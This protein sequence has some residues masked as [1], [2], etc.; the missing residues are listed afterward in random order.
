LRAREW[1]YKKPEPAPTSN[2]AFLYS[3]LS[4]L[5]RV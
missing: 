2:I 1:L 5:T 4:M 3:I